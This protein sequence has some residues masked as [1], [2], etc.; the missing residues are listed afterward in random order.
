MSIALSNIWIIMRRELGSYFLSPLA[1]VL[2]GVFYL[3]HGFSFM[4]TLE[5]LNQP[6][7]DAYYSV[8]QIFFGLNLPY[9]FVMIFVPA[10]LTMRLLSEEYQ[11]GTI[12]VLM[13]APVNEVEVV[14]AKYLAAL[15]FFVLLWVPSLLYIVILKQHADPDPG[16]ILLGYAGTFGVGAMYLAIGLLCSA[17]TRNQLVS[18]IVAM[19]ITLALFLPSLVLQGQELSPALKDVLDYINLVRHF[20]EFYNK[21]FFDSRWLVYYGSVSL[22]CLFMTVRVLRNR[23]WRA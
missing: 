5:M 4:S 18:A 7:A 17:F 22:A 16:P 3:A 20:S 15:G 6:W 19:V 12:E 10:L 13:T 2:F 9:W 23:K 1:Y 8:L 11:T 21:G 14:L